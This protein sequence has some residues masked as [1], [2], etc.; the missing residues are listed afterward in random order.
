MQTKIKYR[1]LVPSMHQRENKMK[2]KTIKIVL[3]KISMLS[4]DIFQIAVR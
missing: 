1:I 2:I 3:I 4:F